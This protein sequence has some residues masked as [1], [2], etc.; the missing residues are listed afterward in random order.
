MICRR[1]LR[2]WLSWMIVWGAAPVFAQ[3][4]SSL[5]GGVMNIYAETGVQ[6]PYISSTNAG[7]SA[8]D[9]P[10]Q[11][12]GIY[13]PSWGGAIPNTL[14]GPSGSSLGKTP[15]KGA[16]GTKGTYGAMGSLSL[17]AKALLMSQSGLLDPTAELAKRQSSDCSTLV[18]MLTRANHFRS[19]LGAANGSRG[20]ATQMQAL[21]TPCANASV[22]V[23]TTDHGLAQKAGAV[24]LSSGAGSIQRSQ[25][26][27]GLSG[28]E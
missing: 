28:S 19:S 18:T 7:P 26:H 5:Q 22:G 10:Y 3:S 23:L 4:G 27:L 2:W 11:P 13:N 12:G 21:A 15:L 14:S 1:L 25:S 8:F 6:S 9:D 16:L 20:V 24:S 17:S